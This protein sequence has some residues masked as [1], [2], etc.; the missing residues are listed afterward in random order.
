MRRVTTAVLAT[1]AAIFLAP[2]SAEGLEVLVTVDSS[3]IAASTGFVDFQFSAA[4]DTAQTATAVISD[5]SATNLTPG[6]I[7][8]LNSASGGPLPTNV[9]ILNDPA[10]ITNRARQAVTF[11]ANSN[12]SFKITFSGNALTTPGSADS[13]FFLNVLNSSLGSAFPNPRPHLLITI[14]ASGTGTPVITSISQITAVVVVPEPGPVV[15]AFAGAAVLVA[16]RRRKKA[17]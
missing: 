4:L 14:P 7:T 10:Q 16:V 11:A 8:Y 15:L 12:F 1:I 2:V 17:S 3:S 9:T 13:T 6:G 5:F